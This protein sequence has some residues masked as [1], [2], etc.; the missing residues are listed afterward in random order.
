MQT[1]HTVARILTWNL[2][3][4]LDAGELELSPGN[5]GR[6]NKLEHND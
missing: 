1:H 6:V 2:R 4:E 3:K 5:H